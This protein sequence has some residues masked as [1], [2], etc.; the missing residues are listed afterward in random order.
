M[1]NKIK[2]DENKL[3]DV[4][5]RR[6]RRV[7]L[8]TTSKIIDGYIPNTANLLIIFGE[9]IILG[10]IFSIYFFHKTKRNDKSFT[11]EPFEPP[12]IIR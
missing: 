2:Q 8:Q 4:G 10:L 11:S 7:L 6:C 1:V 9:K 12:Y 3:F 5:N